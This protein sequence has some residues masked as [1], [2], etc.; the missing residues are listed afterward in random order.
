MIECSS[1]QGGD[2][3]ASFGGVSSGQSRCRSAV[4]NRAGMPGRGQASP[5]HFAACCVVAHE[6]HVS[7]RARASLAPTFYRFQ[8]G[9]R[10][11]GRQEQEW[12]APGRWKQGWQVPGQ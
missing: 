7:A 1:K 12:Q 9:Q 10:V 5:L 8:Q 11:V 4:A 2:A 3:R 6:R